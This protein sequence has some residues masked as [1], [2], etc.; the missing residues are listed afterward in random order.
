MANPA[1][2]PLPV[3]RQT[4]AEILGYLAGANA[5]P[6]NVD[7]E[8]ILSWLMDNDLGPLAQARFRDHRPALAD[9]LQVDTY[10]IAAANALLWRNL[11]QIDARFAESG[12]QAVLLKGA[13]LAE[14]VYDGPEQ[15]SMTDLDLWVRGEEIRRACQDMEDLAFTAQVRLDRPTALRALAGG[16]FQYLSRDPLPALV[17]L[18]LSPFPGWWLQRTAVIDSAGLWQR[19]ERMAD[20]QSFYQLS[21]EDAVIQLAVHL[22]VNHQFGYHALRSLMDIALTARTRDVDWQV[23]AARAQA[24]RVATAVWMALHYLRMLVGTPGLDSAL[25]QLQPPSW[26]R[27]RLQQLVSPE[28]VLAGYDIS[29]GR[30]RYLFLLLLVDRPQDAAALI[31]RTLWPENEWLA[32]RYGGSTNHWRHLRRAIRGDI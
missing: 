1:R 30:K 17:E 23:V 9:G 26:R 19:R 13:A 29:D 24:W 25:Q 6:E 2:S 14:T 3:D 20:W 27:R 31:F 28:A 22:V 8:Q 12:V 7:Q 18:H 4:A 5:A 21:P 32:A 10:M 16:E 11:R 15:R